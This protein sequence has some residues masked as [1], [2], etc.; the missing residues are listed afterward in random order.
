M[1]HQIQNLIQIA[2]ESVVV[3][4]YENSMNRPPLNSAKRA[5]KIALLNQ[6]IASLHLALAD[7][8]SELARLTAMPSTA[9]TTQEKT[10]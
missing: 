10:C 7:Y 4:C 3:H 1:V 6:A 5:A 9:L 2:T 8:E